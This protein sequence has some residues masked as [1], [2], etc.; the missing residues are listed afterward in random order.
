M[1]LFT[2]VRCKIFSL[3]DHLTLY[4]VSVHQGPVTLMVFVL[5]VWEFISRIFCN[6]L[7]RDIFLN[8][9]LKKPSKTICEKCFWKTVYFYLI[10]TCVCL[11]RSICVQLKLK[12][13]GCMFCKTCNNPT[14]VFSVFIEIMLRIYL[15]RIVEFRLNLCERFRTTEKLILSFFFSFCFKYAHDLMQ[16]FAQNTKPDIFRKSFP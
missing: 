3:L 5:S 13:N 6:N 7:C 14:Q 1:F 9:Y 16:Q 4:N 11:T 12:K 10:L 2:H 8:V 15:D